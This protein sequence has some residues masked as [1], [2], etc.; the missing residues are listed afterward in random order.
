MAATGGRKSRSVERCAAVH[1]AR[2]AADTPRSI[3]TLKRDVLATPAGRGRGKW[4][5]FQLS[6]NFTLEVA[7]SR[8]DEDN[9]HPGK[10]RQ[11]GLGDV[12]E[13]ADDAARRP[14]DQREH[15]RQPEVDD[16]R[17]R[18]G[19][20]QRVPVERE[21]S[22]PNEVLLLPVTRREHDWPPVRL[23]Q[24][25][26][27]GVGQRAAQPGLALV[28]LRLDVVAQLRQDVLLLVGRKVTA[29][30]VEV[31]FEQGH[32]DSYSIRVSDALM[33]CHSAASCFRTRRP[34]GDS[35]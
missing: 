3:A 4:R 12:E 1:H 33:F 30:G 6:L 2:K 32:G 28:V 11:R 9:R 27:V 31:A 15:D 25:G 17:D 5:G 23:E 26:L 21:P 10:H 18:Q 14:P 24:G 34:V 29:D 8:R 7:A 16:Q 35:R 19:D 20:L 22:R 13:R